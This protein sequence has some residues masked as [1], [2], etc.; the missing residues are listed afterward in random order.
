MFVFQPVKLL[1]FLIRKGV[2][3]GSTGLQV[4][5]LYF[6]VK[7]YISLLTARNEHLRE[8]GKTGP[9]KSLYKHRF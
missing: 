2:V 9:I 7:P 5:A 3:M 6:A 4:P 1:C 8:G